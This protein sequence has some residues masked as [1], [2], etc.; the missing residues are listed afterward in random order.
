MGECARRL[1]ISRSSSGPI[2]Y[3]PAVT[4]ERWLSDYSAI[5]RMLQGLSR[6]RSDP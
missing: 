4:A 5:A 1:R 3:I 6:R 2:G